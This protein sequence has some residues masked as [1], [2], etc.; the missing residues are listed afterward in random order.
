MRYRL[1]FVAGLAVGYVL[2]ARAGQQRYEQIK[3]A[4]R[5]IAQN[6]AVRNSAETA[7]QQ[8]KVYAGKALHTVSEKVGES[9]PESFTGRVRSRLGRRG[10]GRPAQDDW[11]TS[12]P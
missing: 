3:K 1:T 8:G 12:H 2:G 9:V 6:P 5:G 11:G 7:A 4:V 10:P